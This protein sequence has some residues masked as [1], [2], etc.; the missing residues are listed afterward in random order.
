MNFFENP[1]CRPYWLILVSQSFQFL[2]RFF[3]LIRNV[4]LCFNNAKKKVVHVIERITHKN[5]QLSPHIG[6]WQHEKPRTETT[7]GHIFNFMNTVSLISRHPSNANVAQLR[8]D[9]VHGCKVYLVHRNILES[10]PWKTCL[11]GFGR[12]VTK[13]IGNAVRPCVKNTMSSFQVT[14]CRQKIWEHL[15]R[16]IGFPLKMVARTSGWAPEKKIGTRAAFFCHQEPFHCDLGPR[17]N[18]AD[19]ANPID[20]QNIK[21]VTGKTGGYKTISTP[22]T[23]WGAPWC[24]DTFPLHF[25]LWL[26]CMWRGKGATRKNESARNTIHRCSHL[27]LPYMAP[28]VRRRQRFEGRRR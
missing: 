17:A 24:S 2:G 15:S 20:R 21:I 8:F 6:C 3:S 7:H 9:V 10:V 4:L 13:S 11:F 16:R 23:T 27:A 26:A 14:F 18:P 28:K 22:C 25:A 19:S 5:L 12:V 1:T